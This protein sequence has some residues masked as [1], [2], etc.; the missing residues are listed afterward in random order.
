MMSISE[1]VDHYSN[2]S[3][4]SNPLGIKSSSLRS[5]IKENRKQLE[6]EKLVKF[7]KKLKQENIEI[8]N[9]EGLFAKLA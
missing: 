4:F 8:I 6:D 3:L 1:F 9:P 2:D 5:Y 7:I